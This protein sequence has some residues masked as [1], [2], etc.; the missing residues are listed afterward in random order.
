MPWEGGAREI[1]VEFIVRMYDSSS[2][3]PSPK[4]DQRETTNPSRPLTLEISTFSKPAAGHKSLVY[5]TYIRINAPS[6]LPLAQGKKVRGL[7][8][9]YNPVL[10]AH[11]PLSP[12]PIFDSLTNNHPPLNERKLHGSRQRLFCCVLVA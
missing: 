6:P 5:F 8:F 3:Q 9:T 7:L 12:T 1:R 4:R 2:T 11:D 10:L